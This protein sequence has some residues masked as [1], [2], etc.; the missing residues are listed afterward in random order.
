MKIT[1]VLEIIGQQPQMRH[2]A[3]INCKKLLTEMSIPIMVQ[4]ALIINDRCALEKLAGFRRDIICFIA[5]PAKERDMPKD[6]NKPPKDDEPVK[7]EAIIAKA[8]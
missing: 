4:T 3:T 2:A 8:G 7:E 5:T 1:Q 6:D